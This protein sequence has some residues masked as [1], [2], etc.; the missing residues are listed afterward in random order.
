MADLNEINL[1][2]VVLKKQNF[3][4]RR[5]HKKYNHKENGKGEPV[6]SAYSTDNRTHEKRSFFHSEPQRQSEIGT[7]ERHKTSSDNTVL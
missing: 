4:L 7:A 2:I 5:G 1:S 3:I 6:F